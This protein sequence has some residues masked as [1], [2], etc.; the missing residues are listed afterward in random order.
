MG[1]RQSRN[2]LHIDWS[3]KTDS[4]NEEKTLYKHGGIH[5]EKSNRIDY[6]ANINPLG[7]PQA[8]REA[9]QRGI[10]DAIY[11]PDPACRELREAISKK[12]TVPLE[13]IFIGNG[14]AELLFLI[15]QTIKPNRA[16]LIAPSFHEYEQALKSVDCACVYH[17]LLEENEF[18]IKKEGLLGQIEKEQ[19]L[20]LLFLCNPNN[21]VGDILE[22]E[23]LLP[24]LDVCK[25]KHIICVLDECFIE[26]CQGGSMVPYLDHYDNLMIIKAFTKLYAMPGLRLGYGMT[27]HVEL[28]RQM[29]EKKQPWNV[30][31]PAQYAGIAALK[32]TDFVKKSIEYIQRERRY[33]LEEIKDRK[34]CKKI[35]GSKANYIFFQA[36][37]ALLEALDQK[38]FAIRDC[39]NYRNLGKGYYR[40]AIRRHEENQ[41]LVDAWQK[42]REAGLIWQK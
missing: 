33:L 34:L 26:F 31:V 3:R 22:K 16:L 11:Y 18:Q 13:R 5:F 17:E 32:E 4:R 20:E 42:I 39:S 1:N 36:E 41:K 8:V 12:E 19:N 7:M 29:Q 38:G 25:K 40:I 23:L 21:P 2:D 24:I 37:E 27:S 10:R 30:S 35:Y 15:C 6:T 14:A 28:L 9:A